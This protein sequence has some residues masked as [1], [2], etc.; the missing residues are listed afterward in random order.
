[1]RD[2]LALLGHKGASGRRAVKGAG[3]VGDSATGPGL[4][5]QFI[6]VHVIDGG[7]GVC[8]RSRLNTGKA[9]WWF[10]LKE[11]LCSWREGST[12]P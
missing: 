12:G 2:E 3:A 11:R 6:R 9:W 8:K 1:M 4:A 5:C 7:R 10:E